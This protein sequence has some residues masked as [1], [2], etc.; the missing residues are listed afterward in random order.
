LDR[1]LR[2]QLECRNVDRSHDCEVPAVQGGNLARAQALGNGYD[3]GVDSSEREI[4]VGL[5]KLGGALEVGAVYMFD[6]EL[7][8]G[9][10]SQERRFHARP[11]P[12][13]E[14]VGHLWDHEV[15]DDQRFADLFEPGDAG[16]MV[17]IITKSSSYERSRID[18]YRAQTNP[19]ASR[20]SSARLAENP[21]LV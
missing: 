5:D 16:P 14:Q 10:A 8:R 19:S 9:E 11:S 21:G 13:S 20:L 17:W 4:G 12:G 7:S 3:R 6:D 2:K 18:D 1:W 15:R